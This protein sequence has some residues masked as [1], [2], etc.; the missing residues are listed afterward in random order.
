MITTEYDIKT[1]ESWVL[2]GGEKIGP[3]SVGAAKAVENVFKTLNEREN[4]I[5]T[6][7]YAFHKVVKA[8]YNERALM[9]G[10]SHE[11][12][13][14]QYR[15]AMANYDGIIEDGKSG[16]FGEGNQAEM[17]KGFE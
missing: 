2:V 17:D 15:L 10:Y 3:F 9:A 16:G 5:H 8:R 6:A 4:Q 14:E 12:A 13:R 1:D 11:E 7:R